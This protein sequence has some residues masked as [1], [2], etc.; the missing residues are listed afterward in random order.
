MVSGTIR[1]D[2]MYAWNDRGN[3]DWDDVVCT[4]RADVEGLLHICK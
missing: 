4:V 3:K 2:G 1:S